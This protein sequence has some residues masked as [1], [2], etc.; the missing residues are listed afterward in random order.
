[1]IPVLPALVVVSI[2]WTAWD[3]TY[4]TFRRAQFQGRAVRVHGKRTYNVSLLR[5]FTHVSQLYSLLLSFCSLLRGP[6]GSVP[7]QLWP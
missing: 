5:Y 6:Y 7:Q 3:P 2:L 4:A 1:M